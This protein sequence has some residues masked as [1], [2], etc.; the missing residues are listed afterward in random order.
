MLF[1]SGRNGAVRKLIPVAVLFLASMPGIIG[2]LHQNLVFTLESWR[3]TP[4][5][6][7][8]ALTWASDSLPQD[9]RFLVAPWDRD[10]WYQLQRPVVVN[11]V[12]FPYSNL[13]EWLERSQ[14]VYGTPP[15]SAAWPQREA[16]IRENFAELTEAAILDLKDV[17][18][19]DYVISRTEYPFTVV[20]RRGNVVVYE[21][22]GR[23]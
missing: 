22:S 23:N 8:K 10:V 21:V 18:Q 20:H 2:G 9:A 4:S 12:Y 14:N 16:V 17:Y 7:H 13:A 1:R 5:D 15:R 6:L 3:N 19:I 11:H